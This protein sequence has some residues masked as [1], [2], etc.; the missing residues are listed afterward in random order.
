MS[1]GVPGFLRVASFAID[2]NCRIVDGYLEIFDGYPAEALLLCASIRCFGYKPHTAS[3]YQFTTVFC[4]THNDVGLPAVGQDTPPTAADSVCPLPPPTVYHDDTLVEGRIEL[5]WF[6]T[7]PELIRALLQFVHTQ[8]IQI[9]IGWCLWEYVYPWLEARSR[10]LAL[11][12]TIT[13]RVARTAFSCCT[14]DM[15]QWIYRTEKH[16][17]SYVLHDVANAHGLVQGEFP[18]VTYDQ[19]NELSRSFDGR[20]ELARY[21]AFKCQLSTK[22]LQ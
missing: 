12:P 5:R 13:F 8:D 21:C 16:H 1:S 20:C 6:N 19:I 11:P 9:M 3:P 4:L 7:E 14:F 17:T 22:L 10:A 18:T 15:N 2:V